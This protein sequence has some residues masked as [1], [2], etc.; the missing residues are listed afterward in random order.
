MTEVARAVGLDHRIGSH[1]LQDGIGWGG[2]CFPKDI[3]ALEG[4]ARAH[5][6]D[7]RMLRAANKVN[8]GQQRWVP[9]SC[10]AA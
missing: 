2:S 8:L 1:L 6:L 5:G 4:M 10:N 7:G 9:T 3:V